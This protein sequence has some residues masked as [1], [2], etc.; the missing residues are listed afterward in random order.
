MISDMDA[1]LS[2]YAEKTAALIRRDE[3]KTP[4]AGA[5]GGMGFAFVAYLGGKLRSGISLVMR[6]TDLE[7]KLS[8][9]DFVVTGEG[10]LDSQS[11]MGKA[12]VGVARLAKL[13]GKTVVAFSGCVTR[14][15]G[16]CNAAG[17]DAFF[18]ILRAPSTLAEAMDKANAR[19]N[20]ADTAEQVFRLLALK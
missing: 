20:L 4:G 13:H 6:E 3:S 10:R 11:A 12:P 19:E 9:A 8:D 1:A 18:P 2:A 7:K 14:D 15:A 17:I 5:A 16:V